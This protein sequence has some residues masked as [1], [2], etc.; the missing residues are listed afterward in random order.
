MHTAQSSSFEPADL[1]EF[2][3]WIDGVFAGMVV[4]HQELVKY[5]SEY[6]ILAKIANSELDGCE[7]MDDP[8][9][10]D[11]WVSHWSSHFQLHILTFYFV[12]GRCVENATMMFSWYELS[13]LIEKIGKVS[14]YSHMNH[15]ILIEFENKLIWNVHL[16]RQ[17]N[18]ELSELFTHTIEKKCAKENSVDLH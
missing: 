9:K 7:R 8:K 15:A 4:D 12:I 14:V 16:F 3:K 17:E 18:K 11:E 13:K 2:I 6:K 1:R 5:Y 10:K